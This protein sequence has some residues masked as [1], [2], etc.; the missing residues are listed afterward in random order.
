ML[1]WRYNVTNVHAFLPPHCNSKGIISNFREVI[2]PL[3]DIAIQRYNAAMRDS[4][5]DCSNKHSVVSA[6]NDKAHKSKAI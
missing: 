4:S 1:L 6:D 3:S 2:F 5:D